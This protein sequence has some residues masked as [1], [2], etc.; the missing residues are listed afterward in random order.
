MP[1]L[2]PETARTYSMHGVTFTAHANS[3][4][5]ATQLA[6]WSVHFNPHTPGREHRMSSEEI[7]H[8]LEGSLDV[9]INDDSFSASAGSAV[10]VP[11]GATFRIG[12]VTDQPARAWVVTTLGMTASMTADGSTINPPWAQ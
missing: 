6:G 10:L 12:N 2:T 5:G 8:V 1:L 7:L 11:A 3:S 9:E 4:T